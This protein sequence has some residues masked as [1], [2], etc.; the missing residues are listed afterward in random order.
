MIAG[1]TLRLALT[2][3]LILMGWL[4]FRLT[5]RLNLQRAGKVS[6]QIE[7]GQSELPTIV[8]FTTP[9]CVPC[10]VAQRP[11]L[12]RLEEMLDHRLQ[13]IEVNTYERP[14]MAR[15]WGVMSVPTTFILDEQGKPR[16]VNYGVT[17]AE[18]LYEQV[19]KA[20]PAGS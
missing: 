4:A 13:V 20:N 15:E 8:Y 10:K 5:Q 9:D 2:V 1:W 16:Q 14:D 11:A 7:S 18:K 3:G 19:R 12:H 17:P 6:H